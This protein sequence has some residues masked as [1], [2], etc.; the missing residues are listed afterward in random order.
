MSRG[1]SVRG[2]PGEPAA[3]S[4]AAQPTMSET[5]RA[6][7]FSE[8]LGAGWRLLTRAERVR[9][10]WLT[11]AQVFEGALDALAVGAS[12]PLVAI[13]VQPDLIETNAQLRRLHQLVGS[14]PHPRLLAELAVAALLLV[15]L[16]S[17][18][19]ALLQYGVQRYGAD[20]QNR[21]AR[22]LLE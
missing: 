21:L 8:A 12:L 7:S 13:V 17:V 18:V 16:R 20:C 5:K 15:V 14:P 1:R 4:P 10:A 19:S 11:M 22:D 2:V 9:G 3:P 6:R